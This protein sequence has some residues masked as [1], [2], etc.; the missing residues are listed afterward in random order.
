MQNADYKWRTL[1]NPFFYSDTKTNSGI[2]GRVSG[3]S[4]DIMNIIY[5]DQSAIILSGAPRIGKTALLQYLQTSLQ[6]QA[7]SWREEDDLIDLIESRLLE[8]THFVQIDLTPLES[9]YQSAGQ[10]EVYTSFL[11]QCGEALQKVYQM[12]RPGSFAD[13]RSLREFLRRIERERPETRCFVILDNIDRLGMDAPAFFQGNVNA[14]NPQEQGISLLNDCGVIR[15]LTGLV[16]EFRG[17]GVILALQ[18]LPRARVDAQFTH[19]SAD[20]AHFATTSLQIFTYN[21]TQAFLSQGPAQ[22][23]REWAQQF[24]ALSGDVIFSPRERAWIYEQTGSHPYILQQFCLHAFHFKQ[25]GAEQHNRW[26]DLEE[27]ARAALV[28]YVKGQI[29]TFLSSMWKRLQEA[30]ETVNLDIRERFFRFITSLAEKRS[31]KTISTQ[32]WNDL[33]SEIQYILCNEGIVRHDPFQPVYMPGELLKNYLLQRVAEM[34][35]VKTRTPRLI[36]KFPDAVSDEPI[37]LSELE[38]RLV[39][40]LLQHPKRSPE[41]ELMKAGWSKIIDSKTFTQRM[42]QLRKK[43]RGESSI[44]IIKNHYGGFYSLTHP[45]WLQFRD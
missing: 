23:G 16:E 11:Q 30:L 12:E 28:E 20:L 18:S 26:Q 10:K 39:K 5:N 8:T 43:L 6:P 15:A 40:A 34:E 22:F 41:N 37:I 1:S 45:E 32:G 33:G 17:F 2:I 24:K 9:I 19:V 4:K 14:K 35:A 25:L 31:G 27:E 13:L 42:Y 38:Y 21:D 7:N 44:E 3:R 36:I 29:I